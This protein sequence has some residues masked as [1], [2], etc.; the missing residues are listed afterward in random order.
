MDVQL[1]K[2]FIFLFL[3][4]I[5]IT[6]IGCREG[7]IYKSHE[8]LD[9]NVWYHGQV[10]TFE[11]DIEQDE[12]QDGIL[13]KTA[14]F[15]H[16]GNFPLHHL[17]FGVHVIHENADTVSFQYHKPLITQDTAW[18]G[19]GMGNLFDVEVPVLED[20]DLQ[21]GDYKI[22]ITN[23]MQQDLPL[24]ASVGFTIYEE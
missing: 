9:G 10:V 14:V 5:T 3:I 24:V 2:L 12:A 13:E 23:E 20:Y 4:A 18:V 7:R 19:E 17:D 21:P 11:F 22:V 6:T 8:K 16:S 15:R 1:S